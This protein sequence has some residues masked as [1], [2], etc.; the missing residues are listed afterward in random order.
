[1]EIEDEL[2]GGN[3]S[4]GVV[5]IGFTVRKSWTASTPS[6]FEYMTALRGAGLEVP[7]VIGRDDQG[8]QVTELVD[9]CLDAG[10]LWAVS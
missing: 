8:R 2:I 9:A 10:A 6:V 4:G 5:R 1:M 7:A 3:A